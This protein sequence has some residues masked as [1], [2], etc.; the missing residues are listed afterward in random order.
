MGE[1][2]LIPL[3]DD[4]KSKVDVVTVSGSLI[5]YFKAIPW[6]ELAAALACLY[7]ALRIVEMIGAWRKRK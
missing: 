7:T 1:R 6:P 5:G 4:I 2:Q 3:P